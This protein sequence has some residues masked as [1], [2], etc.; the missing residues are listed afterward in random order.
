MGD[1]LWTFQEHLLDNTRSLAV[2][3]FLKQFKAPSEA[4]VGMVRQG[5]TENMGLEKLKG[6]EKILPK[7][8]EVKGHSVRAQ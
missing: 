5:D 3:I 1:S 2:N 6:L 7:K 8:E 4:V